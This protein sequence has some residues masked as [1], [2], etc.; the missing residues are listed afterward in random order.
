MISG[1]LGLHDTKD[2]LH[3]DFQTFDLFQRS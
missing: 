2:L 1:W 3:G